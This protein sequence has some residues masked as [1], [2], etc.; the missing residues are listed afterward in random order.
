MLSPT[1][2]PLF[3]ALFLCLPVAVIFTVQRELTG[4]ASPE[5]GFRSLS[6]FSLYARNVPD[7]SSP[8][9]RITPPIPKDDEPLL[10]L[11]SQ[12]NPNHPPGSTRK[13]A[14]MYIT[15]TPLPFAPMWEMFFN[16]SSSK[17][18]YNVYIHAD[19]TRDY[20]PGFSGVF[21]NRVIHS[22]RSERYTPT[23][24]AAARRLLAHALLDD[25]QNYIF[26]LF[27]PSCVPIRS[28]DF[29]YKTLVSSR[30]S[31]I[32]ILKD[33]PWQLERWAARGDDAM[34][35]EVKLEDFRI[36]SQFWALTRRHARLVARDRRIWE[37]FN[38]TCVR[39]DTCYPEENYF[40]TLVNMRDPRGCVPATLTHVDWT[41]NDGGHPRMYEAEEVVPE[42]IVRL[43]KTRPRYGEDGVNGSDWSVS[44]RSDP[45]L[46]ARKFSPEALEPLL[47]MARSVLFNDS[48]CGA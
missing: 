41:V 40:P 16:G 43:R 2:F 19:P 15:T 46:F 36:G 11:A 20:D 26:A 7:A 1:L 31:F 22:K 47:G 17:A 12:V 25:P 3:C 4:V 8:P 14:F 28:F 5:F 13:V 48:A 27:S 29:T 42:L 35:P 30:K 44:K 21:A 34:L 45:F 33:E 9:L 37:K 24:A 6:V 10:R 39:E 32:E 23:L 38:K 18:L